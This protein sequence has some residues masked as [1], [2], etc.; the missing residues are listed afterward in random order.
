MPL[1][2]LS[3]RKGLLVLEPRAS[4]RWEIVAQHFS[5]E[6]VTQTL[7]DP[8]TGAWYAALRLGH[9]GVK[10]HRSDDCGK[11]WQELKTPSF[12]PK[13]TQGYWA[14]DPTPWSVEMI[15]S[16]AISALPHG[17]RLWAGC[18]PAGVFYSDDDAQTWQLCES[19]WMDE[20]RKVWMG[21]G[22]DYPGLHTLIV[23]PRDAAH[24]TAAI[25]CGGMWTTYDAGASWQLI[26]QGL[27]AGY[28]PPGL[29]NEPNGQD[30]HRISLCQAQPDVMWLQLH[31]GMYK[32][33]D[34]GKHFTRLPKHP[35]VGDFGFTVLADPNN[36]LRAWWVP[37]QADT[38]RYAPGASM[39]VLRTDDGGA[40]YRVFREGLP[41]TCAYDL[42]YRHGLDVTPDGSTLAMASTTGNLWMSHDAGQTWQSISTHLP[43][44]AAVAFAQ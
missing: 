12:P 39:C 14:D 5:G 30:P 36:P 2:L 24:V 43:P 21:G 6:P 13:P 34:H 17:T 44:V 23:D 20:R 40:S 38:H 7:T 33:T 4:G 37:A 8:H 31:E 15:W 28:V 1:L 32:S 16:L 22:N 29:A 35:E 27:V 10:L 41:Q 25:S 18:M 19:F 3:T 9:F 26:G 11:T 42:V